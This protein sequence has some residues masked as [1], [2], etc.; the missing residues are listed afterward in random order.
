MV[1]KASDDLP[2]PDSPVITVRLSRGMSTSMFLRLCSRAPRTRMER[3]MRLFWNRSPS[4]WRRS[5]GIG[6]LEAGGL[7]WATELEVGHGWQR[8]QGHSGG[9]LGQGP[10]SPQLPERRQGGEL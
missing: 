5:G 8:E 4:I 7:C 1:S 9:Q 10:G 2:E 3:D 6:T